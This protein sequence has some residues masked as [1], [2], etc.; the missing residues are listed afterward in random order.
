MLLYDC[1]SKE[2]H[3]IADNNYRKGPKIMEKEILNIDEACEFLGIRPRTMYKLLKSGE[4]PAVKIGG[5]WRF[6]SKALREL[7]SLPPADSSAEP[8]ASDL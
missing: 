1:I 4:I 3:I 6:S 5:Q 7:F 8:E 2:L